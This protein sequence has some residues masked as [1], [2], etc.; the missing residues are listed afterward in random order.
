MAT[1]ESP[2]GNDDSFAPKQ[3]HEVD[4]DE[5]VSVDYTPTKKNPPIHN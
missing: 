5:F 3:E 4:N 2:K 1:G